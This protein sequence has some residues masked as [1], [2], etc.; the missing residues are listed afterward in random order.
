MRNLQSVED[1]ASRQEAWIE[2]FKNSEIS[3]QKQ[4]NDEQLLMLFGTT[5][6]FHNQV[7]DN[8]VQITSRGIEVHINKHFHEYDIPEDIY[9]SVVGKRVNVIYDPYNL[10]RILVTDGK[11][12]RFTASKLTNSMKMPSALIDYQPGDRT[13][14]NNKLKAMEEH[15]KTFTNAKEKRDSLL[16]LNR[17]DTDGLLQSGLL[18]KGQKQAAELAYQNNLLG[19]GDVMED[20]LS[21]M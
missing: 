9:M 10:D 18:I 1:G 2:G 19:T 5:H 17:I 3:R 12:V 8:K 6:T 14:L 11:S 15:V 13:R 20:A 4:I 16:E 21:R 7:E